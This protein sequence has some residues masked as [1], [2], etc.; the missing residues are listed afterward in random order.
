[1]EAVLD[2]PHDR[3]VREYLSEFVSENLLPPVETEALDDYICSYS[4]P[5][6][7]TFPTTSLPSFQR[8]SLTLAGWRARPRRAVRGHNRTYHDV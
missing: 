3:I 1:M 4:C 5:T 2:A 6:S 7:P 8:I